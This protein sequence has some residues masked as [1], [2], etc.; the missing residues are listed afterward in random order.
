MELRRVAL[1]IT[2]TR[3]G[4]GLVIL[5]AP[6]LTVGAL[7]G[8]RPDDAGSQAA[9][10]MLGA[11]EVALGAGGAIAVGE[12]QQS[13][14]WVSMIAIADGLDAVINL[15][16]PR[17]GW[18]GRVIGAVAAASAAGHLALAKRLAVDHDH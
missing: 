18:R 5:L 10:R 4:V 14:G 12:R 9:A 2:R 13:A 7:Y 17:L 16:S 11:R 1:Y 15:T 3:V 8:T 6:R